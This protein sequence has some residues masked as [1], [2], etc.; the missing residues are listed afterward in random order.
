[1]IVDY[2]NGRKT[3][4]YFGTAKYSHE[5]SKRLP[6]EIINRIEYPLLVPSRLVD[7]FTRRYFY[8]LIVKRR[9]R[10]DH[11]HH[12]TNQDLAFLLTRMDL[13]RSVVTCYDL[14]PWVFMVI[15]PPTGRE[16]SRGSKRPIRS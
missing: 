11:I 2:I 14:I 9:Q 8:P 1:M 5:I 15:A 13:P 4:A 10:H 12:I 6:V 3:A 16:I 7:G